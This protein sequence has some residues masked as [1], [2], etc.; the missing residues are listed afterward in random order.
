[1]KSAL[2]L[3]KSLFWDVDYQRLDSVRDADF[4]IER[5]LNY[6]DEK[7]FKTAI[8]FYG[9]EMIKQSAKRVK[10][11]NEKNLNFWAV[12]FQIPLESFQWKKRL[13]AQKQGIF[14]KR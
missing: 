5:V 1:M 14:L 3:N 7:D 11:I 6:G 2:N 4:I 13:S 8:N 9:L 12:I 10:Y